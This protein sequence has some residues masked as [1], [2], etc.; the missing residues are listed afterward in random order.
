MHTWAD[1]EYWR[2]ADNICYDIYFQLM[3][4]FE[5]RG[6]TISSFVFGND[7]SQMCESIDAQ[8]CL[9]IIHETISSAE[10]SKPD[11][12]AA[13]MADD[14]FGEIEIKTYLPKFARVLKVKN[15][16]QFQWDFINVIRHEFEHVIQGCDFKICKEKLVE[17]DRSERNFMLESCEVPAYVHGFRIATRSRS[18]FNETITE[19]VSIHGAHLKLP[20][21]EVQYTINIWN[22]Y[23]KNLTKSV[24]L[25]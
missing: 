1:S 9:D 25:Q 15:D 16:R 6:K 18:H 22:Q 20:E 5:K 24:K 19:Y 3:G 23:L 7:L 12:F 8:I 21:S 13:C 4:V 2:K 10:V 11:N 17:Y 14:D